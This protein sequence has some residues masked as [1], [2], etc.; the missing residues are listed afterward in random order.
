MADVAESSASKLL[1]DICAVDKTEEI[2]QGHRRYDVAVNLSPKFLLFL[3]VQIRRHGS[4]GRWIV[5]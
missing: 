2:Q 1:T 4:R 3:G 5:R